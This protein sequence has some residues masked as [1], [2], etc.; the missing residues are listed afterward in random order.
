MT[1]DNERD[2]EIFKAAKELLDDNL[3]YEP[4]GCV[5]RSIPDNTSPGT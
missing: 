5:E 3:L 4:L 1:R 2:Y